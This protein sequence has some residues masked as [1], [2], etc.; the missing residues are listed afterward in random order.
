[1]IVGG[2]TRKEDHDFT[3]PPDKKTVVTKNNR[4]LIIK[5]KRY[6]LA[7]LAP[8]NVENRDDKKT[9][10]DAAKFV[11]EY[12]PEKTVHPHA[13]R[14]F[15][16]A[17][18]TELGLDNQGK[19]LSKADDMEEVK[20][21][22]ENNKLT[23]DKVKAAIQDLSECVP[24]YDKAMGSKD[25]E[26]AAIWTEKADELPTQL[27]PEGDFYFNI[28]A[29]GKEGYHSYY[30][31]NEVIEN[32][33]PPQREAM[34]AERH[35]VA[36]ETEKIKSKPEVLSE[37]DL[38]KAV[39]SLMFLDRAPNSRN[40]ASYFSNNPWQPQY[41][42]YDFIIK[43]GYKPKLDEI[44]LQALNE[45]KETNNTLNDI[46]STAMETASSVESE[47]SSSNEE[48]KELTNKDFIEGF[49]KWKYNPLF[50]DKTA[51]DYIETV[52]PWLEKYDTFDFVIEAKKENT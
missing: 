37:K 51:K 10:A 29:S 42:K 5:E 33:L 35:A 43:A 46:Q 6:H 38:L 19:R 15:D 14:L 52:D 49:T 17:L 27:R 28:I 7:D 44:P 30:H 1:M 47:Y 41:A 22:A 12:K 11:V 9:F 50:K 18:A 2:V 16:A 21:P 36:L 13:L 25:M 3:T 45:N 8:F 39:K 23:K 4:E 31:G 26:N 20:E 34:T 32:L 24:G 40:I 48:E